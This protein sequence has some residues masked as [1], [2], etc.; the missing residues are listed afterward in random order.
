MTRGPWDDR[1]QHGGPPSALLAGVMARYG[2]AKAYQMARV[3][4][5]LLRPVPI[6]RLRVHLDEP[7]GKSAQR[8][9]A[10]LEADGKTV[11]VARAIRIRQEATPSSEPL[12]ESSWPSPGGFDDFQFPFFRS[13]VGYHRGVQVR[14]VEGAWGKTP[15]KVWARP[16]IQL[17]AGEELLPAERV[18]LLADAQSGIGVPLDPLQYTFLNPDLTVYLER[19]PISEWLGFDIRSTANDHGAGLSQSAIRDERGLV[20][21]SAQSMVVAKR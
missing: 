2:N 10:R 9:E 13:D 19:Q 16:V 18:V 7:V 15:I 21:R 12:S 14:I 17:I 4:I 1:F 5:D 11:M 3:C 6:G 8:L 20:A